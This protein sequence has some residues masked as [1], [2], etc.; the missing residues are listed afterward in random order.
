MSEFETIEVELSDDDKCV[1]IEQY[2]GSTLDEASVDLF[3]EKAGEI[4]LDLPAIQML[5]GECVLNA[6]M[7]QCIKTGIENTLEEAE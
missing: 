1:L 7:V 2:I 3:N 4:G 6:S 5:A